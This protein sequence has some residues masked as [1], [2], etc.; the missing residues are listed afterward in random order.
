[1]W[2]V[3]GAWLKRQNEAPVQFPVPEKDRERK[4]ERERK[5]GGGGEEKRISSFP[6]C[7]RISF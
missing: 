6:D 1:M 3:L 4:R 7:E 2:W 5:E